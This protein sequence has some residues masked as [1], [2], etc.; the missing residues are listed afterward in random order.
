MVEFNKAKRI[1]HGSRHSETAGPWNTE[2]SEMK[3]TSLYGRREMT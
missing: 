1:I 3:R 2:V